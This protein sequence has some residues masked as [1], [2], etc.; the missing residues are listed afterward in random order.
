MAAGNT[1]DSSK[2]PSGG[3][4]RKEDFKSIIK[5]ADEE[6]NTPSPPAFQGGGTANQPPAGT[7]TSGKSGGGK[8]TGLAI[9][10]SEGLVKFFLELQ[11]KMSAK[12][13]VVEFFGQELAVIEELI[14]ATETTSGPLNF[15]DT[16]EVISFD[17]WVVTDDMKYIVEL[18]HDSS[19]SPKNNTLENQEFIKN[20]NIFEWL[21]GKFIIKINSKK[22]ALSSYISQPC[23]FTNPQD[24]NEFIKS[25]AEALKKNPNLDIDNYSK[26]QHSSFTFNYFAPTWVRTL[27]GVSGNSINVIKDGLPHYW[28]RQLLAHNAL[29]YYTIVDIVYSDPSKRFPNSQYN[30]SIKKDIYDAILKLAPPNTLLAKETTFSDKVF[31]DLQIKDPGGNKAQAGLEYKDPENVARHVL[32]GKIHKEIL[33]I[34]YKPIN[35]FVASAEFSVPDKCS[36]LKIDQPE[37]KITPLNTNVGKMNLSN[38]KRLHIPGSSCTLQSPLKTIFMPLSSEYMNF[39]FSSNFFGDVKF[40]YDFSQN[41]KF[42]ISHP[43]IPKKQKYVELFEHFNDKNE[44]AKKVKGYRPSVANTA[45]IEVDIDV[46][47]YFAPKGSLPE[48]GNTIAIPLE[49]MKESNPGPNFAVKYDPPKYKLRDILNPIYQKY[50]YTGME[51]RKETKSEMIEKII[52]YNSNKDLKNFFTYRDVRIKEGKEYDYKPIL[53]VVAPQNDYRLHYKGLYGGRPGKETKPNKLRERLSKLDKTLFVDLEKSKE[54][55]DVIVKS[56][57]AIPTTLEPG[58]LEIIAKSLMAGGKIEIALGAILLTKLGYVFA[59]AGS[60]KYFP[61]TTT[62]TPLK[63]RAFFDSKEYESFI[64]KLFQDRFTSVNSQAPT[65]DKNGFD[66]EYLD[67]TYFLK[68]RKFG[69]MKAPEPYLSISFD[70]VDSNNLPSLKATREISSVNPPPF[71]TYTGYSLPLN[72]DSPDQPGYSKVTFEILPPMP[73]LLFVYGLGGKSD[74]MKVL[75]QKGLGEKT[76]LGGKITANSLDTV[77]KYILEES[78]SPEFMLPISNEVIKSKP[79]IDL[80]LVSNQKKYIRAKAVTINKKESDYSPIYELEIIDDNG[81]IMPNVKLYKEPKEKL[82]DILS[83]KNH[84]RIKP[85]FLQQA[86]RMTDQGLDLGHLSPSVFGT[87]DQNLIKDIPTNH[88]VKPMFKIR[89]TSKKTGRKVDLN[90]LFTKDESPTKLENGELVFDG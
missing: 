51:L 11:Q 87:T 15:I 37:N 82:R 30:L 85:A 8:Q 50:Y 88:S 20:S 79:S 34:F 76:N 72:V 12:D 67:K 10:M 84:I 16:N 36:E 21:L 80:K 9:E 27:L 44:I 45:V 14:K 43:P 68:K 23:V 61:D 40:R 46:N 19:G 55:R 17:N 6:E 5:K 28:F 4:E 24:I 74:M 39:S 7:K 47:D 62:F 56:N 77:S 29:K 54:L 69:N 1:Y 73:P 31:D 18:K 53:K 89:V 90:V 38:P 60:D 41:S 2:S 3:P 78:D 64:T 25:F 33:P 71:T 65:A 52:F 42:S 75:L 32:V 13:F 58:D 86:P 66:S 57:G 48:F 26:L 63:E 59:L 83:F 49:Y 70:L 81:V 35:N 22:P